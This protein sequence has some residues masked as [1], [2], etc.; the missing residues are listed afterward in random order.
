MKAK[1][2]LTISL[3]LALAATAF[4]GCGN[5]D[6]QNKDD[7][8]QGAEGETIKI[9]IL[10]PL[11]GNVSVYGVASSNGSKLAIDKLNAEG[12][13]LGKQIEIASEDEEGDATKA[14]NAYN[15]LVGEGIVA[16]V[17]DVTSKPT[18]SV[19]QKSVKDNLPII[20]PTATAADVT[21]FGTNVYRTC[22]LDP[23]QGETMASYAKEKLGFNTVAILYDTSD[24]YSIG[25]AEAFKAKAESLDMTITN[26][27]AFNAGDQD[28]KSQ[29][30]KIN[31]SKPDAL[32]IPSYYNTVALIATQAKE[33][34]ITST[35]MGGDG[36]DGTLE[37][38]TEDNRDAIEGCYFANHYYTQDETPVVK[39]FV[40]AYRAAYGKD[41]ISFSALGYDSVMIL[42][43]AIERAGSTDKEA[44]I[45]A[46]AETDY[47][48]VTGHI[49]YE[50]AEGNFGNPTKSV[51][52]ITIKDGQY[53]LADQYTPGE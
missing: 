22:F 7:K 21:T 33:V 53:A 12:G 50:N 28:F 32:F 17:G 19:A 10:A 6:D 40:E 42:A 46:L 41:P 47:T 52:I 37:A 9:G 1:K 3:A 23:Y 49:T 38:V 31:T 16:L 48:G 26:Y 18:I 25:I 45:A 8:Q 35:L 30:T 34:G 5:K 4:A 44:I 36:W 14:V 27:E 15:K 2:I 51:S 39:D 29:L 43:Q 24:D 20:T 11:T 13:I